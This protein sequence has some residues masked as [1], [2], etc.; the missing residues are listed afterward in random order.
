MSL[1]EQLIMVGDVYGYMD[2]RIR[3]YLPVT[4]AAIASTQLQQ[5]LQ[6]WLYR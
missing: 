2:R 5:K 4:L 1:K 3:I 6:I